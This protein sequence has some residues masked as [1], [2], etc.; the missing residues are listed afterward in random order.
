MH[1]IAVYETLETPVRWRQSLPGYI[2]TAGLNNSVKLVL[3]HCPDTAECCTIPEGTLD[4]S[5][6]R[7]LDLP[8]V[9]KDFGSYT[10]P[11]GCK[12]LTLSMPLDDCFHIGYYRLHMVRKNPAG[13]AEA[14][15][16]AWIVVD[17]A[18]NPKRDSHLEVNSIRAQFADLFGDDNKMLE[19]LEVSVGDIA[20]AVERCLQ[21]WEA[22]AP[23]V[24][25]YYGDNFP[26]PELLRNGVMSML[27]Q[28]VCS[29]LQRNMQ[30]WQ[31]EGVGVNL[32]ARLQSYQALREEYNTL[33]R[34]GMQQIKH[35]ENVDAFNGFVSYM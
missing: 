25:K 35:E 34:S 10:I 21:Q 26:W 3:R 31:A 29:L 16:P 7:M 6:R 22:T 23:R 1:E 8:V 19:G 4:V 5:L 11:A 9:M 30:T 2:L 18:V 12:E 17:S 20:E 14:V 28:S 13:E 33:W 15:Y 32:E 27:L 24:S